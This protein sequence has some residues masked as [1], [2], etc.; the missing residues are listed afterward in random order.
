MAPALAGA[1]GGLSLE[2]SRGPR[3][4]LPASVVLREHHSRKGSLPLPTDVVGDDP[5]RAVLGGAVAGEEPPIAAAR[6]FIVGCPVVLTE[7]APVA[8]GMAIQQGVN[9]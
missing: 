4:L 2:L 5:E 9:R 6:G 7:V 3:G 1:T 8:C